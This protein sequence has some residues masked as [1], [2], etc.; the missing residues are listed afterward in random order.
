M[1]EGGLEIQ[2]PDYTANLR[3]PIHAGETVTDTPVV[4][5]KD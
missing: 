3:L 4:L 1:V 2:C 5:R